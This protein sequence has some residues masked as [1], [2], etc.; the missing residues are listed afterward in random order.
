VTRRFRLAMLVLTLIWTV[1]LT[2]ASVLAARAKAHRADRLAKPQR[3][4]RVH[5]HLRTHQA[6]RSTVFGVRVAKYARKLLGVPYVYGGS[7]PSSGFDC[8]GFVRYVYERFGVDLPHS[9]YA[10]FNIG[11]SIS[12][13]ALKP[14]DL[15]FFHGL[16]HVGLYIGSGRFIHAP[17]SGTSVQVDSM[18]GWYAGRYDGARRLAAPVV[19]R[20][21]KPAKPRNLAPLARWLLARPA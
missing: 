11:R 15:V 7:S 12:R 20:A 8:S 4:G 19:R 13:G 9:S 14:G 18:S 6:T 17:H 10:D 3:S 21:A 16:G 1:A 5:R 2:P